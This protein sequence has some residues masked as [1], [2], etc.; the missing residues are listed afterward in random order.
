MTPVTIMVLSWTYYSTSPFYE[1]TPA[2][3]AAY[4]WI[5]KHDLVEES[6]HSHGYNITARGQV[7]VDYWRNCPLPTRKWEVRYE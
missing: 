4:D 1:N 6:E 5:I 7:L 3:K 2:I